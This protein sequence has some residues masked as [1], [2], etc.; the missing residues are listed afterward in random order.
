MTPSSY[1][2]QLYSIKTEREL[3]QF[4]L[5]N[6]EAVKDLRFYPMDEAACL[7]LTIETWVRVTNK[8]WV[9]LFTE[10]RE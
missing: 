4:L 8:P 9:Y 2:L 5:S 7:I 1:R 3:I 6:K 10:P